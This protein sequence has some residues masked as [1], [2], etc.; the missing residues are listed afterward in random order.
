[1]KLFAIVL[2]VCPLIAQ[3]TEGITG[4]TP[5]P[6][7][8]HLESPSATPLAAD[9][10]SPLDNPA[11]SNPILPTVDFAGT[12]K[13]D[14]R[15]LYRWSLAA[16]AAGNLADTLSS[17]HQLEGNPL[18]AGGG[19]VF[20]ARSLALKSAFLGASFLVERWALHHNPGLYRTF[21][22]LN[23]TIAGAL[24]GVVAHNMSLH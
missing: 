13:S 1:M 19:S 3:T 9:L 16:E 11:F 7:S 15:T 8:Q 18:L 23:F 2:L 12:P 4:G 17:W 21:A 10:A 6:G 5:V 22:W 14:G 20:D 24:G